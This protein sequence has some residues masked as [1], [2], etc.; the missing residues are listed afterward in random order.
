M[1]GTWGRLDN[2]GAWP[3]PR[4]FGLIA[5]LLVAL[6]AGATVAAYRYVY[7]W[8]PLQRL[9]VS[10][11]LR[12][13]IAGAVFQAGEYQL[14]YL[15]G[16]QINRPALEAEIAWSSTGEPTSQP[17]LLGV[18]AGGR[19]IQWVTARQPHRP[20]HA[21]LRDVVY[22]EQRPLD[23]LRPSLWAAP[24]VFLVGLLVALPADAARARVRRHGRRLKGPELVTPHRFTRRLRGDG[25]G[26]LLAPTWLG[27][28]FGRR[29]RVRLPAALEPSH[30]LIMGDSGT[31]KS[32][33]I[34]QL[35]EQVQARRDTAIVYDPAGE[36]AGQFY[37]PERGDVILNPLDTR[38]PYW[39]PGDEVH[40][41]AEVTGLATALFQEKPGESLFFVEA[42]RGVFGELLA[43]Q[44]SA[45]ELVHWLTHPEE[46]NRR[47]RGTPP[48]AMVDPQAPHQRGGV[49]ATLNLAA[50][51]LELLPTTDEAQGRWSASAWAKERR[52]WVFLTSHTP[53]RDRL[54][55]LISLWLDLLVLRLQDKPTQDRRVW[56]VLDELASLH[57]LPQLQTAITENRKANAPLVLG[58]QGRSQIETR[59]G[60]D[61]ETILSQPAAKV[62]LRV[63]EARAAQWVS[64]MI[65]T[66]EIERLRESRSQGREA[67]HSYGLERQQEPL[68]MASEISGL[69]NLRG[70]LKVQNLV[71]PLH[72]P[73]VAR[74]ERYPPFIERPMRPL[75][76][77]PPAVGGATPDAPSN[78]GTAAQATDEAPAPP[79]PSTPKTFFQ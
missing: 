7:V 33:L 52:G 60:H 23:L 25:V 59:Y 29:P 77:R 19:D 42:A 37:D 73:H 36:Y 22:G 46:L 34:R 48:E 9:Y 27:G 11:Y 14:L 78:P 28:L 35:L 31:G 49:M 65:G 75:P 45:Q 57:R 76:T 68:V 26:F 12:S 40:G 55:P 15:T 66:I 56:I 32:T 63:S 79:A 8:T 53:T 44:P 17:T 24:L 4:H 58:F 5:L 64:E 72:V 21:L 18:Q 41:R 71:V 38:C 70:Y 50:Q 61:A 51:T 43:Y 13:W 2:A 10:P 74:V 30:M 62:F 69:A 16:K 6:S 1:S 54:R 67:S 3:R 47:V 39:S 20:L